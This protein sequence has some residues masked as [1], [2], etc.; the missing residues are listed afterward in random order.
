MFDPDPIHTI[1]KS[2]LPFTPCYH[3]SYEPC[4]CAATGTAGWACLIILGAPSDGGEV[5][6]TIIVIIGV[7]IALVSIALYLC[8]ACT[9]PG[10]VFKH[11]AQPVTASSAMP[12][13][14]GGGHRAAAAAA[15]SE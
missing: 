7:V 10:I 12:H 1:I 5:V 9:D 4:L 11:T 15:V 13:A 14:I 6:R 3:I 2:P 8:T